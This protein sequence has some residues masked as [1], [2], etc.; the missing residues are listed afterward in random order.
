MDFYPNSVNENDLE[1]NKFD[2][3]IFETIRNKEVIKETI[4]WFNRV[5]EANEKIDSIWADQSISPEEVKIQILAKKELCALLTMKRDEFVSDLEMAKDYKEK[6]A[7][8][9]K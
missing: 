4:E 7:N 1:K 6:Q 3:E 9:S 5:I 8:G 2:M